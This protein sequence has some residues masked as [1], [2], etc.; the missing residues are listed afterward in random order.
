MV[1]QTDKER[2]L[3]IIIREF[4][5]TYGYKLKVNEHINGKERFKNFWGG[6]DVHFATYKKPVIGDLIICNTS[7]HHPFEIGYVENIICDDEI[8]IRKIGSEEI[9]RVYNDSFIPIEGLK[10]TDLLEGIQY[11]FY[12]KILKA[13][14]KMHN[15][16]NQKDTN[17][18]KYRFK[19]ITFGNDRKSRKAIISIRSHSWNVPLGKKSIPFDIEIEFNNKTSIKKI[20]ELLIEGGCG[21]REF[22]MT[23]CEDFLSKKEEEKQ[24]KI[25]ELENQLKKLKNE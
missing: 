2:I 17:Y 24:K 10:E 15:M 14:N 20:I 22:E 23:D 9:G 16:K 7:G 25:T 3:S 1:K 13:F 6:Y 12:C 19:N 4:L 18:Y 21:T 8:Y 11:E 5:S